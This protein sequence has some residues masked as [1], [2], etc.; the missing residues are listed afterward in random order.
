MP[1]TLAHPAAILPLR[2]VRFLR[3]APLMIGAVTPDVPYYLPLG[4]SGHPLRLGLDTHSFVSSYSVDLA[5][6]TALL[7]GVVLLREPLTVL[8][9]SRARSLCL[10]ALEPFRR[11]ATEW[12]F[13]PLAILLGVWSHLLWDSFTHAEGWAVRRIPALGNTVTIGWYTGEIF[14]I[15]QYLSSVIGLTI[16]ALWYARLPDPPALRATHDSHQAHTGPALLLIAA[17]ALLIGGVEALRYYAHY[18]GAV[19]QTLDVLLTRGLAWFALLYLFA[20]AVVTL[21]H[22][23]GAARQR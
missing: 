7:L 8:L 13:A 5:L 16:L 10:E 3:T 1:F 20:G 23:S 15:L 21:E 12:L 4:P 9:P 22:R 17:A 18:E 11:R 2:H 14:H 6:G 19:Y